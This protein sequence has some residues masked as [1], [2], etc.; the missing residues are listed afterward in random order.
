MVNFAAVLKLL[1]QKYN[2]KQKDIVDFLGIPLRT[3]QS[4]EYGKVD[5][6]LSTLSKIADYFNISLDYLVGRAK[7]VQEPEGTIEY[8]F[9]DDSGVLMG[10]FQYV[11]GIYDPESFSAKFL[12]LKEIKG[13]LIKKIINSKSQFE[14]LAL[15]YLLN[16]KLQLN[17]DAFQNN[18]VDLII[19]AYGGYQELN[20][21]MGPSTPTL[22]DKSYCAEKIDNWI[23]IPLEEKK[24]I[25]EE[26]MVTSWPNVK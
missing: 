23:K 7:I 2:I 16:N 26:C 24:K 1:R 25:L 5:P 14:F 19:D 20:T 17:Y 21:G 12:Y 22:V 18:G 3:Y 8:A 13:T 10:E 15:V 11:F 4:Y 6:N 9:A